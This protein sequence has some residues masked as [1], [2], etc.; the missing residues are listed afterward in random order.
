MNAHQFLNNSLPEPNSGCLLWEGCVNPAGYGVVRWEGK[1]NLAHRVAYRLQHGA[2]P[3]GFA[4]CHRCDTPACVNPA[5]LFAAAQPENVADMDRKGRRKNAP[6]IGER[7]PNSKLTSA[8]VAEARRHAGSATPLARRFGVTPE[9]INNIR[10]N[11]Q[12]KEG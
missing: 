11:A 7:H 9:Q 2:I 1:A 6:L 3:A 12:R 8:Q 5:H 10:R 4:V